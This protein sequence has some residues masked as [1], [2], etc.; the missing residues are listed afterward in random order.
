M[1]N[2]RFWLG[3]LIALSLFGGRFAVAQ[4]AD[5]L[6]EVDFSTDALP[7]ALSLSDGWGLS[8]ESE[9]VRV[10]YTEVHG[11]T[12]P[13]ILA[14]ETGAD[15]ADYRVELLVNFSDDADFLMAL[16]YDISNTACLS[17]YLLSVSAPL[18][19]ALLEAS[20]P[21]CSSELLLQS[22]V[23]GFNLGQWSIITYQVVGET[24]NLFINGA[25]YLVGTAP[26]AESGTFALFMLGG[27]VEIAS[28]SVSP[29]VSADVVLDIPPPP[30]PVAPI[31]NLT[32]YNAGYQAA[33]AELQSLDLL[34]S[35]GRRLAEVNQVIFVEGAGYRFQAFSSDRPANNLVI[36][37]RLIADFNGAADSYESCALGVR[38]EAIG[39]GAVV[40]ILDLALFSDGAVTLSDANNSAIF[41]S[42]ELPLELD[43]SQALDFLLIAIGERATLFLNGEP[44]IVDMPITQRGGGYGIGLRSEST[45]SRCEGR[46]IW[47][48]SFD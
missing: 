34:P 1:Q 11:E 22:G 41:N 13:Q 15:W 8:G 38:I 35:G 43:T 45:R 24:V 42:V 46:S 36:G 47:I 44:V 31:P 14:L 25:P 3:L 18:G 39:R 28:L 29:A 32:D 5:L 40:G 26:A 23:A 17:G 20:A 16:R 10:L 48:Y 33:I 12:E 21:D 37:G 30:P 4:D 7:P 2:L 27:A 19:D 9:N 6:F